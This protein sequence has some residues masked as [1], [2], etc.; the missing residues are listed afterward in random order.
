MYYPQYIDFKFLITSLSQC[1]F[2]VY[3]VFVFSLE[4]VAFFFLL[5]FY[6]MT[7]AVTF[8]RVDGIGGR[9]IGM[10]LPCPLETNKQL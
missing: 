2:D 6:F 7:F 4:M 10:R 3:V 9:P 8:L 5:L 1:E